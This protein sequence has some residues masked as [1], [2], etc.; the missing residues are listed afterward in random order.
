MCPRRADAERAFG[1][2]EQTRAGLLA[3]IVAREAMPARK[4]R[5]RYDQEPPTERSRSG[6]HR[7]RLREENDTLP[8]FFSARTAV[9][10]ARL[11]FMEV[12][13]GHRTFFG[14]DAEVLL[15]DEFLVAYCLRLARPERGRPRQVGL[16]FAPAKRNEE[17]VEIDGVIWI[18]TS[19]RALRDIEF[20]YLGLERGTDR[21]RP[22]GTTSFLEMTNGVVL[23]D[24]WQFRLVATRVDSA[25]LRVSVY[26]V[27]ASLGLTGGELARASWPDGTEWRASLG[28][29][30]GRL[31]GRDGTPA[32]G[33][34]IALDDTDYRATTDSSG[35]FAITDLVPGPYD[36][37]LPEPRL[38]SLNLRIPLGLHFTAVR[39]SVHPVRVIVPTL[40]EYVADR[41]AAS[42]QF[43]PDDTTFVLGRVFR[44]DGSAVD[45]ARVSF[46][47][48]EGTG[49][50]RPVAAFF[51]TGANGIF[52]SCHAGYVPGRVVRVSVREAS[53]RTTVVDHPVTS[54]LSVLRVVLPE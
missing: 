15:D 2:W 25:A 31:L 42:R 32:A 44:E 13:G 36:A 1:L 4:L 12:E 52:Q 3:T 22:G 33:V 43:A 54:R 28:T 34:P 39:D 45:G 5:I 20:R 10:F 11:G 30:Y 29:L 19:A 48:R 7:V 37:V 9:D 38:A 6:R 21:L 46:S 16:A 14:P 41:C 8:S 47:V 49:E 23:I 50:F 18:D 17:N 35:T 51:T 27:S 53:G 24:R 40:E 26:R